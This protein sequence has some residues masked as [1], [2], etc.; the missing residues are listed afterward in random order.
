MSLISKITRIFRKN[1]EQEGS[2]PDEKSVAKNNIDIRIYLNKFVKQ[3]DKDIGESV[4]VHDGRL[5]VK[6]REV[7]IAVPL[8]AIK[9]NS[10]NIVVRD[11]DMDDALRMGKEWSDNRDTLK[12]DEN[13]MMVQDIPKE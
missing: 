3:N 9:D 7:Y 12:F 11:F 4:A 5:I 6:K 2:A 10:E 13:G 1:D 8:D